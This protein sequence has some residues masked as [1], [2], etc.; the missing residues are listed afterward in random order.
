V[1]QGGRPVLLDMHREF[2]QVA[3]WQDGAVTQVARVATTPE[4][5][6]MFADG[7]GLAD[8]VGWRRLATPGQ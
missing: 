2:A 4:E 6:R 3:V 5:L 1:K 7:L 8:E